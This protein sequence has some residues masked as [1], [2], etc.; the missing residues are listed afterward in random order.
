[1]KTTIAIVLAWINLVMLLFIAASPEKDS[2]DKITVKEFEVV[3]QSGKQR[4]S[5]K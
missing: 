1:M 4:A 2:F 5:I 3:D